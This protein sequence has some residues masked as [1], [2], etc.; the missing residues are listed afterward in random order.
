MP[1]ESDL[2]GTSARALILRSI[3]PAAIMVGCVLLLQQRFAEI[4]WEE[5]EYAVHSIPVAAISA[6]LV[7]GMFSH[8]GLAGYDLL[9]F[10]RIGR[11]V[12]W[13]RALKGG[14]S[15]TVA[16]QVIGFG[17]IS[18]SYVR[19]RI[20]NAN[21]ISAAQAIT[22][23]GY[24]AAG[25]FSG[26]SVLLALLT[27]ID[28]APVVA[29]TGLKESTVSVSTIPLV[30][31]ICVLAWLT[32]RGS[33][34]IHI[35][36]MRIR[37]PDGAWLVGA[38]FLAALDLIP[39]ALC[40]LV[41]LPEGAAPE[42][43]TFIAIYVAAVAAGHIVGSPGAVGPF[44]AVI[45]LALPS[46]PLTDLAAAVIVYRMLYYLPSFLLAVGFVAF[47][48]KAPGIRLE[49]GESLRNAVDW[50]ADNS[51]NA[52]AEL[53]YLGDKHVYLPA[54]AS[55]FVMYGIYG[56]TW[57]ILGDPIGSPDAWQLVVAGLESEARAAGAKLAVYKATTRTMTFW[58][59]RGYRL[60]PIGDEGVIDVQNFTTNGSRFRELR[61][62]L[63]SSGRANVVCEVYAPGDAP[64]NTIET[65][66]K[67][68]QLAKSGSEQTFSMGHWDPGFMQRH[69]VVVAFQDL[70]PIAFLSCWVSGDA[71]E[72]TMDLMRQMPA[73]PNGTMHSL[74]IRA[75]ETAKAKGAVK[76]NL[77]AAPMSGLNE[78][79]PQ[80]TWTRFGHLF[81]QRFE[82]RHGL[83]GMRRFKAMFRPCW[84]QRY[85]VTNEITGKG[86]ALL[87]AYRLIHGHGRPGLSETDRSPILVRPE[88]RAEN[89]G[90][91]G[92]CCTLQAASN[93]RRVA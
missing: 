9:A 82:H 48:G 85:L 54:G 21:R 71:Q 13:T 37:L 61:R 80:T 75:I 91:D 64:L 69:W 12:P 39:A 19:K 8:L 7:L 16:S 51:D 26:L 3:V 17:L 36:S 83:S 23:T 78:H 50:I 31:A 40:L 53:A 34:T 73:I 87:A 74:V 24:V 70:N 30:L 88:W 76:F 38:T 46:V 62:K 42:L 52:E 11:R 72:W 49:S 92:S 68:W 63:S 67:A 25:F 33:F 58:Q 15:G 22:L 55:A 84:N 79:T 32:R 10:S 57:L 18:G 44:E 86:E 1:P 43:G 47:A 35:G 45:F 6:A 28:P 2:P 29:L 5:I 14:F 41:L 89:T 90:T 20:Y 81:Y 66:A 4:E 65:V 77:C 59:A 27:M 56:R 93:N 60:D